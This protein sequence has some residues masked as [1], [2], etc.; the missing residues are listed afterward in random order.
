MDVLGSMGNGLR[1]VS[2][3]LINQG[4]FER[5]LRSFLG[6]FSAVF[7]SSTNNVSDS[8]TI[9]VN[10]SLAERL[11]HIRSRALSYNYARCRSDYSAHAKRAV[12]LC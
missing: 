8:T 1:G 2:R 9:V 4:R 3:A 7:V 5:A 11:Q 10:I 6:V 12:R